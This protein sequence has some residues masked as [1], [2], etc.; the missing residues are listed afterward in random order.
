MIGPNNVLEAMKA[1][2]GTDQPATVIY[3]VI[4]NDV[5][6]GHPG[7]SHMTTPAKFESAVLTALDYLEA[8]LAP[9]SHVVFAGL[10]DGRLLYNTMH[11]YASPLSPSFP[12]PLSLPPTLALYCCLAIAVAKMRY[13]H[14]HATHT[15]FFSVPHVFQAAASDR[16]TL[17]LCV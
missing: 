7:T 5:C 14:P 16:N 3:A 9:D 15:H 12:L 6:S 4:G 13:Y 1:R 10:V 17:F 2:N 8:H 11:A